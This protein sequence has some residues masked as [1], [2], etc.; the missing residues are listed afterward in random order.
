MSDKKSNHRAPSFSVMYVASLIFGA[1]MITTHLT[2]GSAARYLSTATNTDSARVAKFDVSCQKVAEAP[3]H[4]ELDFLDPD[5]SQDAFA[6]I[7]ASASEVSLEYEVVILLPE[8]IAQL[9][10]ED[11]ITVELDGNAPTVMN[12]NEGKL[13]FEGETFTPGENSTVHT[14]TFAAS[15]VAVPENEENITDETIVLR[16]HAEQID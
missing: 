11:L 8:A 5:K 14:L 2:G 4:I 3:F 16:I 1:V 10:K 13:V 12:I 6:F 7:A 15:T 9:V